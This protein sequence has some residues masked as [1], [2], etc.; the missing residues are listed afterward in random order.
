[1]K[2]TTPI[3]TNTTT[4]IM[5]NKSISYSC[6][7]LFGGKDKNYLAILQDNSSFCGVNCVS[8]HKLLNNV[9]I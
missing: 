4:A 6:F 5:C 7:N 2:I 9:L 8:L 3:I 1:M